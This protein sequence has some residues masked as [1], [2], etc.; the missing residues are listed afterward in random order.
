M[1]RSLPVEAILFATL[2]MS[3]GARNCPF[4]TFTA[5]PLLQAASRRSVCLH[6]HAGICSTSTT[7]ATCAHCDA[8][9]TTVTLGPPERKR[10]VEGKRVAVRVEL[11]GRR[12]IK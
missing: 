6:R 8:S 5:A 10:V 3:Q 9:C 4:F 1:I 12:N 11:G 2:A 7:F